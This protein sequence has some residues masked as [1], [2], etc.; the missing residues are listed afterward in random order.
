MFQKKLVC[1]RGSSML[2]T[3]KPCSLL[4]V[5]F[6][7][8]AICRFDIVVVRMP[9][10][11]LVSV[12]RVIGLPREEVS[13]SGS[14]LFVDNKPVEQRFT[15]LGSVQDNYF[16]ALYSNE[17]VVLGDNRSNSTDSRQCGAVSTVSVMGVV[18]K[19]LING[20]PLIRL[21]KA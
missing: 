2:P 8:K 9:K 10:S 11:S 14:E 6:G 4:L 1:V 12:K 17:Y 20:I 13:I 3:L 21:F 15:T 7:Y 19:T 16:W 18:E 5:N